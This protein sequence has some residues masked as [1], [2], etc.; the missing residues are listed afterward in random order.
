M[1]IQGVVARRG[2]AGRG[3]ARA[4]RRPR[5]PRRADRHAARLG[6]GTQRAGG[7]LLP[8]REHHPVRRQLV[9]LDGGPDRLDEHRQGRR[10]R[11]AGDCRRRGEQRRSSLQPDETRA[12]LEQTAEDVLPGNTARRRHARPG[13]ARLGHALRL[14]PRQRRRRGRGGARAAKIPPEASID[15]PDWYAP[16]TGSTASH[17]PGTRARAAGGQFNWK[18]EW[19]PGPRADRRGRTVSAGELRRRRGDR[20]RQ[21]STSTRS[22]PRWR[23]TATPT[24]STRPARPST[25]TTSDP[26]KGQFTVRAGRRPATAA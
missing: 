17:R 11:G 2:G 7:H 12:L 13:A 4:G 1:L 6:A 15:S 25:A 3:A 23:R 21:R 9:D 24:A 20:L 10:R 16:L 18:L 14:R 5:D 19:R 26:Y 22:A 8:R